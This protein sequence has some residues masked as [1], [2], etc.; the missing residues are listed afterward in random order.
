MECNHFAGFSSVA[1]DHAIHPRNHRPMMD[2]DGYSQITGP[3]GYTIEF[4]LTARDGRVDRASFIT[5]GQGCSLACG[6]MAA[7]LAEGKRLEDAA[8]LR[9]KDIL[10]AL[11][12]LPPESEHCALLAANALKTACENY[13][14]RQAMNS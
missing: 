3:Y 12:G 9:P 5:N 11:G 10:D 6:S 2:S 13:W 8:N 4:W 7:S 14:K 1:K